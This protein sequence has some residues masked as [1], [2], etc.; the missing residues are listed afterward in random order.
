MEIKQ[1]EELY[2]VPDLVF[3]RFCDSEYQ[4]NKGVYNT[5]DQWF[6]QMGIKSITCRRKTI[7]EFFHFI[8]ATEEC[9]KVKFG[10]GGL[11]S[12]LQQFWETSEH[13]LTLI[14]SN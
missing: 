10:N 11:T 8:Q 14:D 5:I 4:V 9:K 6:Y 7:I 3:S 1:F 13:S 12:R 2:H